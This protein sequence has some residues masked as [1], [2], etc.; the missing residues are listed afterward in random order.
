MSRTDTFLCTHKAA[1]MVN[2]TAVCT[3]K[4]RL[5]AISQ[6]VHDAQSSHGARRELHA[7]EHASVAR[8]PLV[9]AACERASSSGG[10]SRM[11]EEFSSRVLKPT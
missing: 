6:S 10:T 11:T 1:R 2:D 9:L 5:H 3:K 8:F 4:V 7:R